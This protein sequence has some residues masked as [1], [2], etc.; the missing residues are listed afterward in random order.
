LTFKV[1]IFMWRRYFQED[2]GG[3]ASPRPT[4]YFGRRRQEHPAKVSRGRGIISPTLLLPHI[5]KDVPQHSRG[6][7]G[8][9]HAEI[10]AGQVIDEIVLRGGRLSDMP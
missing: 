7:V 9:A 3:S 5:A 2:A 1:V 6:G 10:G 4:V 8:V